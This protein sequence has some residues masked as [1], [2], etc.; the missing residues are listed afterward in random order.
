MMF[1]AGELQESEKNMRNLAHMPVKGRIAQALLL[2]KEKFGVNEE[3]FLNI[4]LSRQDIASF[5]GTTYETV[6]R[7]LN[8]F[9]QEN[10]I[11]T[12]GKDI[13]I[14]NEEKLAFFSQ[15]TNNN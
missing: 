15:Q 13:A 2:L 3:N 4:T 14:L 6:F 7:I 10:I 12:E 9:F 5:A 8:E 1:F 11:A